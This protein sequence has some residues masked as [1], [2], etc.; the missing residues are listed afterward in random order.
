[1]AFLGL[2][3]LS[4]YALNIIL[5]LISFPILINFYLKN[6]SEF[7]F[8]FGIDPELVKNLPT[9]VAEQIHCTTCVICTEEIEIGQQILI[10]RCPGRHFFHSGC[11]KDWLLH[12]VNC[13]VCRSRDVI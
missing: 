3:G 12:K 4:R 11:I 10:L 8:Q 6:P 1:M 7:Y 13:P 2:I 9:G 5:F